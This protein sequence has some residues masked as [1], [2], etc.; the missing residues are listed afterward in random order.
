MP[1]LSTQINERLAVM[2][3]RF[4][5]HEHV[6]PESD[7]ES[8]DFEVIV[9]I[10]RSSQTVQYMQRVL[11]TDPI[12][13]WPL[14]ERQGNVAYDVGRN[15]F[16][17]A[18]T[19]VTLGQPGT[20]DGR[21]APFYDGENDLT[22][23]YTV[24]FRDAFGLYNDPAGGGS[25]EGTMMVWAKVNDVGVWTDAVNRYLLNL[26]VDSANQ[27]YLRK[28]N[29]NNQ[30]YWHYEAGNIVENQGIGGVTTIDWFTLGITWSKSSGEVRYYYNG[31][32]QGATEVTLGVWVGNLSAT[33]TIIGARDTAPSYPWHG[34]LGH[35]VVW[36]YARTPAQMLSLSVV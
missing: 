24:S 12:A 10:A 27:I 34:W 29:A 4:R 19:G 36:G 9:G 32:Q 25:S 15:E 5:H 1:L 14:D 35:C 30:L 8:Y 20:G 13:Y 11:A 18:Y 16:H 28:T 26:Y 7:G 3:P 17:G 22:N 31:V 33:R 21:T 2:V 6:Y 23:I